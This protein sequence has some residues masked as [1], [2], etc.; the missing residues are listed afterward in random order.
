MTDAVDQSSSFVVDQ[1]EGVVERVGGSDGSYS[2]NDRIGRVGV[3]SEEVVG[4]EQLKSKPDEEKDEHRETRVIDQDCGGAQGEE[5]K[6]S[7]LSGFRYDRD[8]DDHDGGRVIQ[9]F[10]GTPTVRAF[11]I[12][13]CLFAYDHLGWPARVFAG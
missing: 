8:R 12:L 4:K 6:T 11:R 10:S 9:N 5:Q 3:R 2:I 1:V 7:S 13:L